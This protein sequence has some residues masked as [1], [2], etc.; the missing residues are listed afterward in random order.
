M[1]VY[2][3]LRREIEVKGFVLGPMTDL[4]EVTQRDFPEDM[5]WAIE[6]LEKEFDMICP[7]IPDDKGECDALNFFCL[8][9]SQFPN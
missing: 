9:T 8:N 7:E 3:I 2:E 4:M 6:T 1:R 5:E